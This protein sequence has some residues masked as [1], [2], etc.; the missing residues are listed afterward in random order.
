MANFINIPESIYVTDAGASAHSWPF[1]GGNSR[2]TRVVFACGNTPGELTKATTM[3][4][5]H[6]NISEV[7]NTIMPGFSVL[8]VNEFTTP[9]TWKVRDPRGFCV[10]IS[11]RN[12]AELLSWTGVTGGYIHDKCVWVRYSHDTK[13]HLLTIAHPDY[14]DAASNTKLLDPNLSVNSLNI[15]DKVLLENYTIGTY[16]GKMSVYTAPSN[17]CARGIYAARSVLRTHVFETHD[18]GFYVSAKPAIVRIHTP[19]A[20]DTALQE[21]ID[22]IL[23][24]MDSSTF[25]SYLCDHSAVTLGGHHD[26]YLSSVRHVSTS[27]VPKV[28]LS[29]SEITKAD[30]DLLMV[31][32]I[33]RATVRLVVEDADGHKYTV[34]YP[35][36]HTSDN[37]I[38]FEP[39]MVKTITDYAI[40]PGHIPDRSTMIEVPN[41]TLGCFTKFYRINLHVKN[42]IY[43]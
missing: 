33:T 5:K 15:G 30:A 23:S 20:Q 13:L 19:T 32:D 12:M 16:M 29:L 3:I 18:N 6:G 14:A 35:T 36:R 27:N 41:H 24:R 31:D 26:Y 22:D 4:K 37:I 9:A 28:K 10:T 43:S 42:E 39:I 34:R 8:G 11:G 21:S 40:V 25:Y 17:I 2:D 1:A 7:T 38:R